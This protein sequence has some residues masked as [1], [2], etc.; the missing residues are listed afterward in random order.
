MRDES[1]N[2]SMKKIMLGASI[3]ALAVLANPSSAQHKTTQIGVKGGVSFTGVSNLQGNQRTTGHAGI[4]VHHTINKNWCFQPEVLYAGQGQKFTTIEGDKRTLAL[5]YVQVP[6][7]V[8]YFPVNKFYVEFGP[9]VGALVNAKTKN[10]GNGND[11]SDVDVNYRKIDAG[12]NAGAGYNIT[13][14]VGVYGRYNHGLVDITKSEDTYRR[15]TGFQL[16]AAV[17]F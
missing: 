8:Q 4:F 3:I 10:T 5:D 12:I 7:M 17:R 14:N 6:L 2:E 15:N 13:H 11:K 1:K 16:G 9:Q